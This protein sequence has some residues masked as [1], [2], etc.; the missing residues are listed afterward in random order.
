MTDEPLSKQDEDQAVEAIGHIVDRI[1]NM[2]TFETMT[3]EQRISRVALAAYWQG[4]SD[5]LNQARE[6]VALHMGR[7][8]LAPVPDEPAA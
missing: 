5:G 6:L 2:P 1:T 7:P 3:L 8:P 4:R